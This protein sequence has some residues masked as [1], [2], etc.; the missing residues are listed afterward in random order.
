MVEESKLKKAK[1]DNKI[2]SQ[3]DKQH[4]KRYGNTK[5]QKRIIELGEK[6]KLTLGDIFQIY[7]KDTE[8]VED[9]LS[10]LY[11]FGLIKIDNDIEERYLL[12]DSKLIWTNKKRNEMPI[13]SKKRYDSITKYWNK[14]VSQFRERFQ[15][16]ICPRCG[17]KHKIV[18]CINLNCFPL[19]FD[20]Q[21]YTV[22]LCE[23]CYSEL[24][25]WLDI[26]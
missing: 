13:V 20:T 4:F 23:N 26:L 3:C 6:G 5:Q 11:Y 25:H 10:T 16:D 8:K 22:K 1:K 18:F 9:E 2:E 14:R 12:V 19:I 21:G 24:F 17:K 15:D 7:N